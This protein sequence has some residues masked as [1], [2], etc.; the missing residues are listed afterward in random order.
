MATEVLPGTGEQ[1]AEQSAFEQLMDYGRDRG[2]KLDWLEPRASL[3]EMLDTSPD[4]GGLLLQDVDHGPF[5]E[6]PDYSDNLTGRPRGAT[7]SRQR[8]ARWQL[9]RSHEGRRVASQ[10]RA[11]L[12]RGSAAPMVIRH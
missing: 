5:N 2:Y 1:V 10:W 7:P 4:R 9:H 11:A 12:R 8:T 6:V 3:G